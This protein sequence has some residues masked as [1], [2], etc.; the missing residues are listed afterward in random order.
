[1]QP[2][3][4]YLKGYS[5]PETNVALMIYLLMPLAYWS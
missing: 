2:N 5:A 4:L 3:N 1:M